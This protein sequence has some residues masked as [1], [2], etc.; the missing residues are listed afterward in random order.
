MYFEVPERLIHR[1]LD[2]VTGQQ[3]GSQREGGVEVTRCEVGQGGWVGFFNDKSLEA[4]L[5]TTLTCIGR[6]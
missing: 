6:M 5:P 1:G 3:G 4:L 2:G